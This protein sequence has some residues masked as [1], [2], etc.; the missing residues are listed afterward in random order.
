MGCN[1]GTKLLLGVERTEKTCS[2]EAS[3]LARL[4]NGGLSQALRRLEGELEGFAYSEHDFYASI[5]KRLKDPSKY[6]K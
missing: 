5:I 2:E 6:G 4:H 1:P 3:A